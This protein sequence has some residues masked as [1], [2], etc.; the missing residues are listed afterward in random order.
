MYIIFLVVISE[1]ST[2]F[3]PD[4]EPDRSALQQYNN[5]TNWRLILTEMK[6]AR[7]TNGS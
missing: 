5:I 7:D 1:Y 2:S 3:R 4:I 6:N